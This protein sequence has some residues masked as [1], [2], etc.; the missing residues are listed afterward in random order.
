M[1]VRIKNV[2]KDSFRVFRTRDRDIILEKYDDSNIVYKIDN[3]WKKDDTNVFVIDAG[4]GK[5]M[6][7]NGSRDQK[8][9]LDQMSTWF[10]ETTNKKASE[11]IWTELKCLAIK[12]PFNSTKK[13]STVKTGTGKKK[14]PTV[15]PSQK[16]LD[17]WISTSKSSTNPKPKPR[18]G[19]PNTSNNKRH[20]RAHLKEFGFINGGNTCFFNSVMQA[21]I[22]MK[23]F[24]T[25]IQSNSWVN[26]LAT[27]ES[28][29]KRRDQALL[30][31]SILYILEQQDFN[32]LKWRVLKQKKSSPMIINNVI[33]R[34]TSQDLKHVL[35]VLAARSPL[36][37]SYRQEDAH[38]CF[39]A[40]LHLLESEFL[41]AVQSVHE[42]VQK[43]HQNWLLIRKLS[44]MLED[45][46]NNEN[47]EENEDMNDSVALMCLVPTF[48]AFHSQVQST[49]EC[50]N[51]ENKRHIMESFN[52]LSLD[53]PELD[54]SDE[55]D[56]DSFD[57]T[58]W[59]DSPNTSYNNYNNNTMSPSYEPFASV[60]NNNDNDNDSDDMFSMDD[61]DG[62]KTKTGS[63]NRRSAVS[64]SCGQK[65][66]DR[67]S[68]TRS[69]IGSGRKKPPRERNSTSGSGSA[70]AFAATYSRRNP[71]KTS[72]PTPKTISEGYFGKYKDA[73]PIPKKSERKATGVKPLNFAVSPDHETVPRSRP[74]FNFQDGDTNMDTLSP[75]KREDEYLRTKPGLS[76]GQP[77]RLNHQNSHQ[78]QQSPQSQS[79]DMDFDTSFGGPLPNYDGIHVDNQQY[80]QPEQQQQQQSQQRYQ[81]VSS[82]AEYLS[83]GDESNRRSLSNEELS[84]QPYKPGVLGK[85]QRSNNNHH[86]RQ[87]EERQDRSY[88]DINHQNH[89]QQNHQQQQ[90]RG[91]QQDRRNSHQEQQQ[92]QQNHDPRNHQRQSHFDSRQNFDHTTDTDPLMDSVENTDYGNGTGTP[93][94]NVYEEDDYS[95]MDS[96]ENNNYGNGTGTPQRNVYEEDDYSQ[97]ESY[98]PEDDFEQQGYGQD[99][100]QQQQQRHHQEQSEDE[101]HQHLQPPLDL[102][103]DECELSSIDDS[104]N[105]VQPRSNTTTTTNN[106]NNSGNSKAQKNHYVY[107]LSGDEEYQYSDDDDDEVELMQQEANDIPSSTINSQSDNEDM[108]KKDKF[109]NENKNERGGSSGQSSRR[110]LKEE[111][112]FE[113]KTQQRS[114]VKL[115]TP[116][117][118]SL[119]TP[120]TPCDNGNGET[121]KVESKTEPV[122][123]IDVEDVDDSDFEI[124]K[125]TKKKRKKRRS[126]TAV[127]LDLT[128]LLSDYFKPHVVDSTCENCSHKEASKSMKFIQLPN[129]IVLHAKRFQARCAPDGNWHYKK[130]TNPIHFDYNL[131]IE[132]YCSERIFKP[133][134]EPLSKKAP[135]RVMCEANG[136]FGVELNMKGGLDVTARRLDNNYGHGG[137]NRRKSSN[138][139]NNS[140]SNRSSVEN[141]FKNNNLGSSRKIK[142]DRNESKGEDSPFN[143]PIG[144]SNVTMGS[145]AVPSLSPLASV[146]HSPINFSRK[147]DTDVPNYNDNPMNSDVDDVKDDENGGLRNVRIARQP[148]SD[149][150]NDN[151]NNT[152]TNPWGN[153][154]NNDNNDNNDNDNDNG[155]N[156]Q[157][158]LDRDSGN[159]SQGNFARNFD[160]GR[161]A[162]VDSNH[163]PIIFDKGSEPAGG[164]NFSNKGTTGV[165]GNVY[166]FPNPFVNKDDTNI[167]IPEMTLPP[168]GERRSIAGRGAVKD[169][170]MNN[171]NFAGRGAV[172]D[173]FMV[174]NNNFAGRGAVKDGFIAINNNFDINLD[175]AASNNNIDNAG[176]RGMEV[177]RQRPAA[178]PPD[179]TNL[180]TAANNNIA[181]AG[182]MGMEVARQRPAAMPPDNISL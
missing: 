84:S 33:R 157:G 26:A 86:Q 94:R 35:E 105:Y 64:S 79:D 41:Y 112:L 122:S 8:L 71:K 81:D 38:E 49:Y 9:I 135:V 46:E 92:Y 137:Q 87:Q 154:N 156:L 102:S 60:V 68:S 129:V 111:K 164:F 85:S 168:I 162:S 75:V 109:E 121:E 80:N 132:P 116:K 61:Y 24:K 16:S 133:V 158:K 180:D 117:I 110:K 30:Y 53:L 108:F 83:M 58:K 127:K 55:S 103:D 50:T 115:R 143:A 10:K 165:K 166:Q 172:K 27:R 98:G 89:H 160:L 176:I 123:P 65:L 4:H 82:V 31:R 144:S 136:P 128:N 106:N 47:N 174:N 134:I 32:R 1:N 161:G 141:R 23:C 17:E 101:Q 63:S 66:G 170:F 90:S 148:R 54:E 107:E 36:F 151:D 142:R 25:D 28:I 11:L 124:K 69:N 2:E 56:V 150:D 77:P 52:C 12:C 159:F 13:A 78:Y 21:M 34:D 29:S 126:K 88:K 76:G 74:Q 104:S 118:S 125:A 93:D 39:M 178:M 139:N 72:L 145:P 131:D 167:M 114:S 67:L 146:S 18:S 119:S 171:N 177:A 147:S 45:G 15:D 59:M 173:G 37:G 20:T 130:I 153:N 40:L 152:N 96:M 48:R 6:T 182:I 51:C 120:N 97:M 91:F 140:S 7:F 95:Q 179:D 44:A 73:G 14:A 70:T 175:T 138:T 42:A 169:G 3:C 163:N 62:T 22:H 155:L 5:M 99:Q 149:S 181:N 57:F 100:R 19:I 43:E 113:R